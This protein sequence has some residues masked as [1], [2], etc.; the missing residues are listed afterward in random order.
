M[1][2]KFEVGDIV[3]RVFN[4]HGGMHTGDTAI[5]LNINRDGAVLKGYRDDDKYYHDLANLK[6]I[7]KGEK[8][9]EK[10]RLKNRNDS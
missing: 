9:N 4:S 2:E 5:V 10:V 7:K 3:E 6:L 1:N 8:T